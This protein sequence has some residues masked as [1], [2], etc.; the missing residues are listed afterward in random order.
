MF[1]A[2]QFFHAFDDQTSRPR[3]L[4]FRAHLVQKIRQV[5]DLGFGRRAFDDGDAIGQDRRHHHV[6]GP[7]N[8]RAEFAREINDGAAQFRREH[9][10]VAV[11]DP[12]RGAERFKSFQ[13]QIDRPVANDAAAGH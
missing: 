10:Y 13:M 3:A 1:G 2:V 4:D 11:L 8:C 9:F 5:D 7:E 12:H 6:V